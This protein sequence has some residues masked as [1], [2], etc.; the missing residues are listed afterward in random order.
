MPILWGNCEGGMSLEHFISKNI[1]DQ[2]D[3]LSPK[4]VPWLQHLDGHIT[5]KALVVKCLCE[6]HNNF[7]SPLDQLAGKTFIE[8]KRFGGP[9]Q[10]AERVNIS[11]NLSKG[12]Y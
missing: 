4:G 12:G 11:G 7:L 9:K 5:P 10:H 6:K 2:F 8:F 1:L 3:E